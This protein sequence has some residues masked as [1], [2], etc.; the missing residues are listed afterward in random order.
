MQFMQ[1]YLC[2]IYFSIMQFYSYLKEQFQNETQ[3]LELKYKLPNHMD[4][5]ERLKSIFILRLS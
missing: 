2:S 5:K 1:Y 3:L 4:E